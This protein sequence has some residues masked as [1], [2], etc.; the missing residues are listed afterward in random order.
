MINLNKKIFMILPILML[1]VSFSFLG[2]DLHA[3][4][5]IE[6]EPDMILSGDRVVSGKLD[7]FSKRMIEVDNSR[8]RLCKGV[9]V[10]SAHDMSIPLKNLDAAK[11]VKAFRRRG[12]VR[13]IK[14][15]EFHE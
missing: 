4:S 10:F 9:R 11:T 14:V 8:Y 6:E 5:S 1:F 15:L 12:C 7:S 2:G 13:K 3:A